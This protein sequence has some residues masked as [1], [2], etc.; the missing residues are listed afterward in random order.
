MYAIGWLFIGSDGPDAS[1]GSNDRDHY[2]EALCI[3]VTEHA[4]SG[5]LC[6]AIVCNVTAE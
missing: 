4:L 6:I 1:D 2:M 5:R 3:Q